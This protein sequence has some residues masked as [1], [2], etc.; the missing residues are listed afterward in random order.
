MEL[1]LGV[2]GFQVWQKG[3]QVPRLGEEVTHA[4]LWARLHGALFHRGRADAAWEPN[5][6]KSDLDAAPPASARVPATQVPRKFG[7]R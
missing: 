2:N 7:F 3:S 6:L 5:A 4:F 1:G